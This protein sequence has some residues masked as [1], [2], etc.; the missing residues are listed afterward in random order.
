MTQTIN[1]NAITSISLSVPTLNGLREFYQT[2]LGMQNS[3]GAD[4]TLSFAYTENSCRVVFDAQPVSSY[5]NRPNDLYW[6]IGITLKDLD[7]AVGYL[8]EQGISVSAPR[9]FQ[10]IGYMSHLQDPHGFTIELLQQGFEGRQQ[11]VPNGHPIGAQATLAHITLRVTDIEAAQHY[12]DGMGMRLMSVQPVDDYHFCLYFYGW[13][14][15]ALPN[16]DVT[17]VANREWLWA[18]PYTLIELQH[19]QATEDDI[20]HRQ[21]NEAGLNGVTYRCAGHE[22]QLALDALAPQAR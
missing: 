14:D 2:I 17:S 12:L 9:Q 4:N 6:K 18:R 5:T 13:S 11:H 16:P 8:L 19:L 1:Q 7:A 20:C 22:R 10:N 3:H 15:E 21:P